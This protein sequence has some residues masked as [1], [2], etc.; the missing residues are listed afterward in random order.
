MTKKYEPQKL[1]KYLSDRSVFPEKTSFDNFV[2]QYC[3]FIEKYLQ[4]ASDSSGACIIGIQGPIGVGKTSLVRVLEHA[5]TYLGYRTASCSI[6]NFYK[7][8]EARR[9]LREQHKDNPYFSI[10]R[11]MPGT[12][13]IDQI[14]SVMVAA[15]A[16]EKFAIPHFDKSLKNG[17]GD[18]LDTNRKVAEPLDIFFVEGWCVGLLERTPGDFIN[19][20][21][22]DAYAAGQL[23]AVDPSQAHHEQVFD[24]AK[25]YFQA[26]EIF[27]HVTFL[28]PEDVSYVEHWRVEQE[29][30]LREATGSGMTEQEVRAFL[31]HFIPY[32]YYLVEAP[33][34]TCASCD[35]VTINKHH[36]R[37]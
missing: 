20:V 34:A 28:V 13:D 2:H 8:H 30:C 15:K 26:W 3:L 16:G 27:D 7:T 9:I 17:E 29:A 19:T 18:V 23:L 33:A 35:T 21:K 5:F 11:G 4:V 31:Q 12:H 22:N 10:S 24:Y 6:D 14:R 32:I 36:L 1:Y 37:V 25:T